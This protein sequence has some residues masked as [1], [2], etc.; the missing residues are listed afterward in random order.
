MLGSFAQLLTFAGKWGGPLGVAISEA[1][2]LFAT[3]IAGIL[4]TKQ[5]DVATQ[6]RDE[7]NEFSGREHVG[8]LFGALDKLELFES[9]LVAMDPNT[10]RWQAGDLGGWRLDRRARRPC[11]TRCISGSVPPNN[12]PTA[13]SRQRP[14]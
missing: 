7:L 10:K 9:N 14:P 13:K 2:G 1:L 8:D 6:L 4:G 3:V 11:L 12:R 5:K